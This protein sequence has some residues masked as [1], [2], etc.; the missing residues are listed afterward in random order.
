MLESCVIKKLFQESGPSPIP[1]T[2]PLV[3]AFGSGYLMW[4]LLVAHGSNTRRRLVGN[5]AGQPGKC[6]ALRV[7]EQ[8]PPVRMVH[9]Y[10]IVDG[11]LVV[12]QSLLRP[13]ASQPH[14]RARA[15]AA[16]TSTD[17]AGTGT[18][19]GAG[20][21]AG[22][23]ASAAGASWCICRSGIQERRVEKILRGLRGRKPSRC[24]APGSGG[25]TRGQG[26]SACLPQ[27]GRG[28]RGSQRT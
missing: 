28:R 23:S 4:S 15:A 21:G 1:F 22:A 17:S 26:R 18:G 14:L 3:V 5:V 20:A 10:C 9:E 6:Q 24:D 11:E 7:H 16:A 8:R 2:C 19:T 27:R 12:G 25:G 13:L